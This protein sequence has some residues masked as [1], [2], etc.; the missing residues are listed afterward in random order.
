MNISLFGCQKVYNIRN[1]CEKY[2][3]PSH[4]LVFVQI[5]REIPHPIIDNK[6]AN[7]REMFNSIERIAVFLQ[8]YPISGTCIN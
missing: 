6:V 1:L 4:T 3:L 5:F 2:P 7:P 8:N